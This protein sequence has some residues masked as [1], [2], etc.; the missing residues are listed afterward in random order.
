M[1]LCPSNVTRQGDEYSVSGMEGPANTSGGLRLYTQST[2]SILAPRQDTD[3]LREKHHLHLS[4]ADRLADIRRKR[5]VQLRP[6]KSVDPQSCEAVRSDSLTIPCPTP[7]ASRY[8]HNEHNISG[9]SDAMH[10]SGNVD[11]AQRCQDPLYCIMI[12]TGA[13]APAEPWAAAEAGPSRHNLLAL[14]LQPHATVPVDQVRHPRQP[15]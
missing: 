3:Q 15:A 6:G 7:K 9:R 1:Q 10:R 14:A 5:A 4:L 13:V 2:Q 8:T 12:H 11:T